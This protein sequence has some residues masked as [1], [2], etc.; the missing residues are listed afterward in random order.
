VGPLA[1]L[2]LAFLSAP[3]RVVARPFD[4][5]DIEA[6]S[7][8]SSGGH[9]AIRFS[10]D[11]Y[12]FL[13]A[14]PGIVRAVRVRSDKFDYDYRAYD[15]RGI[16]I[17]RVDVSDATYE[18]LR[19]TFVRRVLVEDAQIDA[20]DSARR[21]GKL[22][23]W[24]A[25]HASR[26]ASP[27]FP[28]DPGVI[29][30]G[31]GYFYEGSS[32][33]A[34]TTDTATS[35]RS[36]VLLRAGAAT[37]RDLR[38]EI[39]RNLGADWLDRQTA[40]L[41]RKIHSL[42]YTR[43]EK[44][45][46]ELNRIPDAGVEFAD[47]YRDLLLARL[48]L[49]VIAMARPPVPGAF[50]T[51]PRPTFLL[52]ARE[53]QAMRTRAAHLRAG[54]QSLVTS[55]RRDRGFPLLVAMARLVAMDASVALGRLVV[56]DTFEDVHDAITPGQLQANENA[57]TAVLAEKQ[58]EL[59][60]A[61][62][63]IVSA[64]PDKEIRWTELEL[65]ANLY[66]EFE[67]GFMNGAL[68]RVEPS[69]VPTRTTGLDPAW[70]HPDATPVLLAA[71]RE[72]ARAVT[73]D[74][75]AELARLYGYDLV[76]RNCVTEIFAT[77]DDAFAQTMPPAEPEAAQRA[78]L[79]GRVDGERDFNFVP[80]ISAAAVNRTYRVSERLQLPSYRHYWLDRMLRDNDSITTRL[81]ESNTLTSRLYQH[82][83]PDVFLFFTDDK[84]VLRPILGA[85]NLLFGTGAAAAGL[86][87][88]P[89]DH[90]R[91]ALGGLRGVLFSIPELAFVNIR[92]GSNA[93]VPRNWMY[94]PAFD[95]AY[96]TAQRPDLSGVMQDT[97]HEPVMADH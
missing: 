40:E 61:K 20:L 30:K 5:L 80:F 64:A 49:D 75:Q 35:E 89:F 10:D 47:R 58:N 7:G 33:D 87:T 32:H 21:D 28:A 76:S 73:D 6:G 69:P 54:L 70:P 74:I 43:T 56:P 90:G 52:D 94:T 67:R 66:L 60:R 96:A 15:N 9:A 91:L 79:G 72:Q 26:A 65:A 11:T 42:R 29:L 92:K 86:M 83:E 14:D 81:R 8:A 62:R 51:S 4:Y 38:E 97:R 41:D 46:F 39:K 23:D 12:H 78:A 16:D 27:S 68:I 22:L 88:L 37:M 34:S 2:T 50:R 85:T 84:P 25:A 57:A 19:M 36:I 53:I 17:T 77:I 48:A 59:A 82:G 55:S 1:V 18:T 45:K 95:A 44:P 31:A 24:L 63:A 93:I 13:N 71:W 3:N